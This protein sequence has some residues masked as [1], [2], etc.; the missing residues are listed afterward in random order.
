LSGTVI[1]KLLFLTSPLLALPLAA[2]EGCIDLDDYRVVPAPDGGSSSGGAGGTSSNACNPTSDGRII[3]VAPSG[4]SASTATGACAAPSGLGVDVFA[5]SPRDGACEARTRITLTGSTVFEQQVHVRHSE[6]NAVAVAG[7]FT[8]GELEF[9]L[10]CGASSSVQLAAPPLGETA[11]Y[12]ARLRLEGSSFCTEWA[13]K[14]WAENRAYQLRAHAFELADDGSVLVGGALGGPATRFEGSDP[15]RVVSGGAFLAN[16]SSAGALRWVK[17]FT[18]AQRPVDAVFAIA[19]SGSSLSAAGFT[20]LED[21]ACHS[22]SGASHV[23]N[24]AGACPRSPDAGSDAATDAGDASPGLDASFDAE[25]DAVADAL[26]DAALEDAAL[27]DAALADARDAADSAVRDGSSD[28]DGP[29][30]PVPDTLN[31]FVFS[32]TAAGACGAFTSFGS[33]LGDDLQAIFGMS[34]HTGTCGAYVAGIAGKNTWRLVGSDPRT[35][36]ATGRDP[37]EDGFIAHFSGGRFFGCGDG[38]PDFSVRLSTARP[39]AAGP[40]VAR[41]CGEGV[42]ATALVQPQQATLALERCRTAQGCD[43]AAMVASLGAFRSGEL[44]VLHLNGE[45]ELG[46]HGTFGPVPIPTTNLLSV[47]ALPLPLDLAG[48]VRDDLYVLFVAD[49]VPDAHNVE[50]AGCSEFTAAD[51]AAGT[52][53]MKLARDGFSDRARCR[54][55]RR[56]E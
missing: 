7:T 28:G 34:R 38:A 44:A 39:T 10:A 24:G 16:W 3:V 5:L 33:D 1:K 42:T 43:Q 19:A 17:A 23:T 27:T 8:G 21:P 12:V 49:G 52:W 40:L 30:G 47:E 48:D 20:Q 36:L 4:A 46:W 6:S 14:A 37:I 29:S 32:P 13:R 56:L 15:L 35:A 18:A 45:G 41:R 53:I 55:A 51:A 11:L 26:E 2:C 22:C 54:W 25:S 31:A 50:L 9:P